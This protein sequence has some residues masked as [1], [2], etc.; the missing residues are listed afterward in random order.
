MGLLVNN[1]ASVCTWPETDA[2]WAL[3]VRF[4]ESSTLQRESQKSD[5]LRTAR[6]NYKM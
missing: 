5:D 2:A 6:T 1:V 4:R 3:R